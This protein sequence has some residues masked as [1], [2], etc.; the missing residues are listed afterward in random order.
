MRGQPA[1]ANVVIDDEP[2]GTLDYVAA[3]GVA[4]APGTHHVT[5]VADGYFPW[6]REVDAKA[7][8]P[9]IRLDVSLVPVP[10]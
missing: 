10:D 7:G 8:S 4:V 5:V 1:K 2:V 3:R 9:A 6:D